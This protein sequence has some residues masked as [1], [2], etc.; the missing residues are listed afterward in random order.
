MALGAFAGSVGLSIGSLD[1]GD[2]ITSRLPFG[3]APAGGGALLVVVGVPMTVAAVDS[4]TGAGRADAT[5][6][7]SGLLL[8]GWILVELAVIRS[9]PWLQPACFAGGAA[10]A[11]A[12]YRG[13]IR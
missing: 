8:M 4:W 5:S 7:G 6:L 1:L 9:F 12:G 10:T 3:S 11:V 2:T 13:R